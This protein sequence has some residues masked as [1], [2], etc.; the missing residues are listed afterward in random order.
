MG[1]LALRVIRRLDLPEDL[2]DGVPRLTLIG[3]GEVRIEQYGGL[4]SFSED[5]VAVRSGKLLLRLRGSGLLICCM[6]RGELSVRGEIDSV[7]VERV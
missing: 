1:N 4:Q 3:S 6:D 7:E 5:H 2:L